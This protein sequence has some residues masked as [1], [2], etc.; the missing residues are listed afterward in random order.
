MHRSGV[1]SNCTSVTRM[2]GTIVKFLS[3][4]YGTLCDRGDQTTVAAT[5]SHPNGSLP[6]FPTQAQRAAWRHQRMLE[7]RREW[8]TKFY[9]DRTK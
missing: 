6:P 4:R 8:L 3:I 2:A 9:T 7:F 5:V 1:L